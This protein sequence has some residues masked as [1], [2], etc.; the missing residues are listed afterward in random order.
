M[1]RMLTSSMSSISCTAVLRPNVS[2]FFF[3]AF[4]SSMPRSE[5]M[6]LKTVRLTF[7]SFLRESRFSSSRSNRSLMLAML[8]DK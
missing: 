7:L 1:E 6:L 5:D 4:L 2:T 8:L 3:F